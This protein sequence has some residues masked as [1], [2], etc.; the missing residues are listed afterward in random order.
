MMRHVDGYS[1]RK[2]VYFRV[3]RVHIISFP[4]GVYIVRAGGFSRGTLGDS[5]ISSA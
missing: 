1:K 4:I 5:R 3:M 2:R